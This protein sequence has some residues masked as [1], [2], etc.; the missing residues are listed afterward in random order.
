VFPIAVKAGLPAKS[1]KAN[2]LL[3]PAYGEANCYSQFG[4]DDPTLHISF[5]VEGNL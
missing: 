3:Q 5:S 1:K 2:K 4:R